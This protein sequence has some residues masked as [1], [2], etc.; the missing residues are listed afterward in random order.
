MYECE[1]FDLEHCSIYALRKDYSA[2][3]FYLFSKELISKQKIV[4]M[5]IFNTGNL[6]LPIFPDILEIDFINEILK[7]KK[8]YGEI[9][10]FTTEEL[11]CLLNFL[12][13][14]IE[15]DF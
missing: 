1:L 12:C 10:G 6:S 4:Y 9:Y 15:Y 11:N 8:T 2:E 7:L 14:L 5:D 13:F 3:K